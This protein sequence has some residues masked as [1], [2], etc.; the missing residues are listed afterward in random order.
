MSAEAIRTNAWAWYLAAV[1]FVTQYY[2]VSAFGASPSDTLYVAIGVSAVIAGIVGLLL[3]RGAALLA[4]IAVV[5]CV[6]AYLAADA[7][8]AGLEADNVIVP[9]PSTADWLYLGIYPVLA[10]AMLAVRHHSS[11]Q[12]DMRAVAAA[13]TAA[14]ASFAL[15]WQLYASDVWN[16]P[17]LVGTDRWVALGYPLGDALLVGVA[18]RLLAGSGRRLGTHLLLA[19]SIASLVVGNVVYNVQVA[20]AGFES[21]GIASVAW[22]AFTSLLG[23][24]VLRPSVPPAATGIEPE[25]PDAPAAMAHDVGVPVDELVP[26]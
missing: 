2:A 16:S 11:P 3:Q 9:F 25:S 15:F 4:R 8:L 13:V 19:G 26:A 18:A 20:G 12:R 14:V 10:A 24:A 17:F 23:G 7:V 21:G 5:A 22:L 1:V 6:G